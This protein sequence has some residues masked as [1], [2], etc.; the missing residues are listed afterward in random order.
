MIAIMDRMEYLVC[1]PQQYIQSVV[2][3][4]IIVHKRF[5]VHA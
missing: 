3:I 2:V 5:F 1:I 4:A